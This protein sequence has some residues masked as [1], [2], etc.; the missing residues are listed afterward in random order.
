MMVTEKNLHPYI[1]PVNHIFL[2]EAKA[3]NIAHTM[4][5]SFCHGDEDK[6]LHMEQMGN[7]ACAV[8][9]FNNMVRTY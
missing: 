8:V 1:L 7:I 9:G 5:S 3:L 2:N 6:V 4:V